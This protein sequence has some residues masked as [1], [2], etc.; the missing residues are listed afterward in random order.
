ML[1]RVLSW[2]LAL[3]LSALLLAVSLHQLFGPVP[4]PVFGLIA[5]RSG[6]ELL[7]PYGRYV[8]AGLQLTAVVLILWSPA[9]A[10]GAGIAALIAAAAIVMHL[11]PWL[12]VFLPAPDLASAALA[13]GLSAS[14]ID[15][16]GLPT[17]NGGMFLL[18]LATLILAVATLYLEQAKR[19][20]SEPLP[21]HTPEGAALTRG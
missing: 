3:V 9:R 14:E 1:E 18:V 7:E 15:A 4:H 6:V 8:A 10:V 11:T 19:R 12:G 16:M 13:E 5:A 21:P 2:A 20:A 17:D